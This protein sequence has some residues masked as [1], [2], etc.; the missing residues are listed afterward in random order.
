MSF[1]VTSEQEDIKTSLKR[2]FENSAPTSYLRSR[3]DLHQ[4]DP[5]IWSELQELG[6]SCY[7]A[8]PDVDYPPT[9]KDLAIIASEEGKALFSENLSEHLLVGPF[10][11]ANQIETSDKT[12]LTE[13]LSND[14]WDAL[15]SG[16]NRFALAHPKLTTIA[17]KETKQ[18]VQVTGEIKFISNADALDYLIFSYSDSLYLVPIRNDDKSLLKG[19]S[20]TPENTIDL[21]LVKFTI[22][23][24]NVPVL[25]FS[26]GNVQTVLKLDAL[27]KS[28]QI[29]AMAS[30]VI[31]MTSQYLKE[32][33]QFGVP[34]GSF[35]ALQH[36]MAEMYVNS[37]ALRNLL[38]F[39]AW[40][41][42]ASPEQFE[43]AATSAIN[44]S[45]QVG[46]QIIENSIQLHGGI[47]FTWEFDLHLYLRR[48]QSITALYALTDQE[49]HEYVQI[50]KEAL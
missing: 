23:L 30:R 12:H 5:S 4:S 36:K 43:F 6:L 37:E 42:D 10:L 34:I 50:T 28:F 44:F 15:S 20:L 40:S 32:R 17:L 8:E 16:L 31:E 21:T 2:F 25:Q 45:H 14:F 29:G 33:K 22:H 19:V 48:C 49:L 11:L 13:N 39:A 24:K 7:F 3:F 41:F 46:N 27:L 38:L 18:N 47:G 35:Q 26:T 1:K 9:F